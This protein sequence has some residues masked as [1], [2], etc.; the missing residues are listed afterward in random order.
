M[1]KDTFFLCALTS[2]YL[3]FKYNHL[4]VYFIVLQTFKTLIH[5]S[6]QIYI[7]YVIECGINYYSLC[8]ILKL[9]FLVFVRNT[10]FNNFIAVGHL[11]EVV[12]II[13]IYETFLF[14]TKYMKYVD[15]S[16]I[17]SE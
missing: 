4:I 3:F 10:D 6:G 11:Q 13:W 5:V 16:V 12:V 17:I 2:I 1:L 7:L 14:Y 15:C 8:K 9:P